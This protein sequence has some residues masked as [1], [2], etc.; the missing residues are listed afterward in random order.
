MVEGSEFE[1][2]VPVSRLS[3]DSIMLEFATARGIA[4]IARRLHAVAALRRI[5]P[6]EPQPRSVSA[7]RQEAPNE[8]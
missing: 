5:L 7:S 6:P 8:L 3:D 1:P 2:P 4:L